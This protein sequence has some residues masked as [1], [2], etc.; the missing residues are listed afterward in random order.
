MPRHRVLKKKLGYALEW[1]LAHKYEGEA[2]TRG[3]AHNQNERLRRG[4]ASPHIR[5]QSRTKIEFLGKATQI[6]G[7]QLPRYFS[8]LTDPRNLLITLSLK[9]A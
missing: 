9:S 4:R 1:P 6:T 5:R 7:L 8:N 3:A 2:Q